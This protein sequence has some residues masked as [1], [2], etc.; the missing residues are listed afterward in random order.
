MPGGDAGDVLRGRGGGNAPERASAAKKTMRIHSQPD[1]TFKDLMIRDTIHWTGMY[2][3][4]TD[5][6]LMSY[7]LCIHILYVVHVSVV[8]VLYKYGV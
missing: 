8:S 1:H 6:M 4:I 5:N 2:V 3:C 7:P